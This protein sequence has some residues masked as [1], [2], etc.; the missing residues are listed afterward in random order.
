MLP[1]MIYEPNE[2]VRTMLADSLRT[3]PER[4]SMLKII[5][6][7]GSAQDLLRYLKE[8]K[9]IVLVILGLERQPE[10]NRAHCLKLGQLVMKQN[11]DSY[12]LFVVH[13]LE[14]LEVLLR[15]C[16]RPAG[17]LMPP[18][19]PDALNACLKRILDDYSSL[20][21]ESAEETCLLVETGSATYRLPHS[22][23]V[24]LEALDKKLSIC[25]S[26]Q[27]VTVRKSLGA[28]IETLPEQQFFRCHRSFVVNLDY[29]ERANFSE[30]MLTLNNGDELPIARSA[31]AQLKQ[32]LEQ[33]DGVAVD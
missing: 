12:T 8:E 33:R 20:S 26:R 19:N 27:S 25:T 15:N 21:G 3:L 23:I 17:I 18:F 30:M 29:V 5:A 9:G 11:R 22:Q 32:L 14:D 31:R 28:V 16:M 4:A 6:V 2:S 10:D 7:T 24:Y 1:V 13:Q